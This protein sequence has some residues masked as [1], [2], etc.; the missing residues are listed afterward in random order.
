MANYCWKPTWRE[1]YKSDGKSVNIT[2]HQFGLICRLYIGKLYPKLK[3][4]LKYNRKDM[5]YSLKNLVKE[6]LEV[7][8]CRSLVSNIL[9]NHRNATWRQMSLHLGTVPIRRKHLLTYVI[10]SSMQHIANL[11][12]RAV[13]QWIK[14][15]KLFKNQPI[16][17]ANM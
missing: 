17:L 16:W 12:S 15:G 3:S 1:F 9:R 5:V 2:F 13:M 7:Q 11:R 6:N 4:F 8:Y 14:L 10:L